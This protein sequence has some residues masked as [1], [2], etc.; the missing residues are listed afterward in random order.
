MRL[1]ARRI[2]LGQNRPGLAEPEI[3][4]P[5]QPLA[6]A[7]SQLDSIGFFD[8]RRQRLA[9]P[10]VGSHSRIT[11][12]PPQYTINPFHLRLVQPTRT[13][14]TLSLRQAGQPCLLVTMYPVLYRTRRIAQ[15]SSDLWA[16]HALRN[17]QNAVPA[18]IVAR[19]FRTLDLLLQTNHRSGV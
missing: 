8:P 13:S 14:A 3:E 12:L 11:R 18:M 1:L 15:Q 16:G 17:Q 9:I 6:L 4:L 5:E 10:Q 2:C 7:H 19:L